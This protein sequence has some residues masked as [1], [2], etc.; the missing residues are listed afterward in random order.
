MRALEKMLRYAALFAAT[1]VVNAVLMEVN[2]RHLSLALGTAYADDDGFD[3]RDDFNDTGFGQ[4]RDEIPDRDD[5]RMPG[6]DGGT[7]VAESD[8]SPRVS[9]EWFSPE[10]EP[11]EVLAAGLSPQ[12][13]KALQDKGYLLL[14]ER[15]LDHLQ[16][17]T[18]RLRVPLR[19]NPRQAIEDIKRLES[20]VTTDLNHVY[21][22]QNDS[23]R[24][25]HC[26][27]IR[28]IAW[29]TGDANC[30]E[31][32]ATIGMI[33]TGV[34]RH[35][36]ALSTQ[37]I[38]V[39]TLRSA[40]KL[41]SAQVH[42][43]A[44]AS[45]LVG[46][47]GSAAPGLL[48]KA[49]VLA[50]DAFHSGRSEDRMDAFDLIAAIEALLNRGVRVINLSFAGPPNALLERSVE[51]AIARGTILIAAAGNDGP[52]A[53]PRYPAAY[54]KVIAVT[55]I[56]SDLAVYR[57][58]GQGAHID[59]GAP[60]VDVW[61]ADASSRGAKGA[62][63]HTGTSYAAPYVTAMVA[64]ALAQQPSRDADS[65]RAALIGLAKDLGTPGFD[66]VFG[67]GLMQASN[68]CARGAGTQR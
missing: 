6:T 51:S 17:G 18:A 1:V 44:I 31:R 5:G 40:D 61:A 22:V 64:L 47:R 52:K 21:R 9:E 68:I 4:E 15:R 56:R 23:C 11:N 39:I 62:K 50:V 59:F 42:G 36:A 43:T 58:A 57:R 8:P 38:E 67:H 41:P 29:P 20:A 63:K 3:G 46:A 32:V 13:I 14:D 35:H 65:V 60:G 27:A 28:L 55:A 34:Q 53:Q 54:P 25:P 49:K 37:D 45:L 10:Y 48:N 66:P 33:D 16:N 26:N 7:S 30:E 12:Q 2:P 19:I 24:G